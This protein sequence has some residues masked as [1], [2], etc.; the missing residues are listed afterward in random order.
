MNLNHNAADEIAWHY[1][2]RDED[3]RLFERLGQLEF[4]RSK[5]ICQRY[6]PDAPANVLDVGGGTGPYAAWLA[7]EGYIVQLID[8]MPHHV[9]AALELSSRQPDTP[10]TAAV[11]D[12][13]QLDIDDASVDVVLMFGPLYHLTEYADRIQALTEA[14]RVLRPGGVVLTA[15]ISRW[16]S[17]LANLVSGKLDDPEFAALAKQDRVN[18]QHRNP[19]RHPEYFTTA[20]FHH[21]HEVQAE[22]ESAGFH[23]EVTLNVEGI[24]AMLSNFDD[25]WNNAHRRQQLLDVITELEAEP[26][27][28]GMTAHLIGIGYKK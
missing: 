9:D 17:T 1:E 20:Y 19:S 21:P 14:Y 13:R 4:S 15:V 16:I 2:Q 3:N 22:L 27:L 18:G 26:T 8:A 23:Y 5:E 28:L 10:F 6:L 25:H 12:A 11:G 7:S 24:A